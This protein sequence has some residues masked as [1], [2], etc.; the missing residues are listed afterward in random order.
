MTNGSRRDGIIQIMTELKKETLKQYLKSYGLP[1]SGTKLQL[2]MRIWD[3]AKRYSFQ[4]IMPPSGNVSIGIAIYLEGDDDEQTSKQQ[5][6]TITENAS[7][8]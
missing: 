8:F 4:I 7:T 3:K 5:N 1:V 2:A 6:R